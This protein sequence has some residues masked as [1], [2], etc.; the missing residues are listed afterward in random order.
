MRAGVFRV[1]LILDALAVT[2][3][4]T[5]KLAIRF[6]KKVKLERHVLA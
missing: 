4:E 3:R 2:A 1:H 5:E 6:F